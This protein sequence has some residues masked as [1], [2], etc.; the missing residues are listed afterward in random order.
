MTYIVGDCLEKLVDVQ[1]ESVTTIYLD[2]PFDSGRD[3]TLSKN[4]ATGFKDTWKGSDYKQFIESVIDA[5]IPKMKKT[6]TLFFH[7]SAEK[8]FTPE[9]VLRS[10][11]KYVQPIFWKK[12]VDLRIT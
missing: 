7:I 4:D 1:D 2:P 10:K 12:C 8:M 11:F 3:Y 9:Q 6:G 5:C